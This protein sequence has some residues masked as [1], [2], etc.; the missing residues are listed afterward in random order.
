MATLK[1]AS[2]AYETPQTL[3]IADLDK[4]PVSVQLHENTATNADGEDFTY[5]YAEFNGKQY[6]VPNSVL[7]ELKTIINLKPDVEFV[8]VNKTGSGLGTRYKVEV[9]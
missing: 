9:I 7:D 6:R 8:K 2:M 5:K 4:V 1:E 3:N